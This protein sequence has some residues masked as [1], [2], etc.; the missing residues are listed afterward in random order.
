MTPDAQRLPNRIAESLS[1]PVVPAVAAFAEHLARAVTD[2]RSVLFYGS[3]LRTGLLDGIL[4]FYIL[5]DGPREYGIWPSVSYHEREADGIVLRAKV[6]TM[7]LA[8]FLAAARGDLIDT[9]IW[10]RFVQPSA[11]VWYRDPAAGRATVEAVAAATVTAARLAVALGPASA[12][13]ENYWRCLFRAT[14]AAEFRM[15]QS[16]REE[17]ILSA[18]REHFADLLPI[19]LKSDEIDFEMDSLRIRPTVTQAQRARLLRWWSL[20]RRTGKVIN[21]VRLV[22]ASTIFAGAARYAAWKIQRHTG[23][24]VTITPWQERHPVLA[25]PGV[26]LQLWREQ[27]RRRTDKASMSNLA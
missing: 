26:L 17:A 12:T 5:C 10:A 11:L 8:T 19:A 15:E 9:T 22:K 14:Y 20:C 13:A 6:A 24:V 27:R 16:G 25:A 4:D 7:N 21:L 18:N 3:N 1:R 23:I 2:A